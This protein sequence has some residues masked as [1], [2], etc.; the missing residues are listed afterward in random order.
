MSDKS[1]TKLDTSK[2]TTRSFKPRPAAYPCHHGEP[3]SCDNDGEADTPKS[4]PWKA[5]R[6]KEARRFA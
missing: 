1:T 5:Y 6:P 4:V 2:I 3:C